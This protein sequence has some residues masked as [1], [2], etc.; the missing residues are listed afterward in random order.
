[1]ELTFLVIVVFGWASGRQTIEQLALLA[2]SVAPVPAALAIIALS[3]RQV[4]ISRPVDRRSAGVLLLVR[5]SA[6]LR[7]GS[8]LRMAIGEVASSDPDLVSAARLAAAGRPM[9]QVVDAM[10]PG[11]GRFAQLTGASI[12]MAASSGGPLA[13]VVEQLVVQAMALDDLHRERRS[14]MAPGLLQASVVG[15]VPVVVLGSMLTSGRFTELV[16][17]G[18]FHAAAA[19][20]GAALTL[21]GVA[22]V[23]RIVWKDVQ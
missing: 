17:T 18:P 2:T 19:L 12:R 7:A 22:V 10:G 4:R 23:G 11:L 8:T 20:L 16:A 5:L 15:G 6:Q 21:G 14:A 9:A 1:M 13:P 3:I